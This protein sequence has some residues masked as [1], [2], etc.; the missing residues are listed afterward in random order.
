[1]G[2]RPS[3]AGPMTG[4][5]ALSA[6]ILRSRGAGRLEIRVRMWTGSIVLSQLVF[7]SAERMIIE[8]YG[9]AGPRGLRESNYY[10]VVSG[11]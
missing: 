8:R 11:F 7:R 10:S 6:V 3:L 4:Q 1:M 2:P 9:T 5:I